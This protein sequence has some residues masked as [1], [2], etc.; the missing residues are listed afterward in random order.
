[1]FRQH[2]SLICAGIVL[3]LSGWVFPDTALG[4][5]CVTGSSVCS[6]VG[7]DRVTFVGRVIAIAPVESSSRSAAIDLD[8][9]PLL[10][11]TF[12][13][14]ETFSGKFASKSVDVVAR[15]PTDGGCGTAFDLDKSYLVLA[16]QDK[17]EIS[18]TMCA[19]SLGL[20]DAENEVAL[21]RE[22]KGGSIRPRL[23][24]TVYDQRARLDGWT[25]P[26]SRRISGVAGVRVTARGRTATFVTQ[27]DSQGH[28]TF[29]GLPFGDYRIELALTSNRTLEDIARD[30]VTV[31]K[32]SG[33][34]S[35]LTRV[36]S[37][38]GTVRSSDASPLPEGIPIW[39]TPASVLPPSARQGTFAWTRADGTWQIDGLPPGQY[40]LAVNVFPLAYRKPRV[41]EQWYPGV[42]L[43]SEATVIDVSDERPIQ[44][45]VNVSRPAE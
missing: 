17:G 4:C 37:L 43:A 33:E 29:T 10:R 44:L 40:R 19:G 32:C 36:T 30:T 34:I 22:S 38:S 12:Q 1:M 8:P 24:G 21:L 42:T 25:G 28:F 31:K 45:A 14:D 5:T 35:L 27:S 41:A 16:S 9:T 2:V 3:A 20:E 39:V 15:K 26:D 7:R 18:T 11:Y 23:W 6:A 13:V